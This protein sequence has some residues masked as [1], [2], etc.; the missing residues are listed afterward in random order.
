MA[1]VHEVKS[2]AKDYP[3]E[4]IKK[5]EPYY[6]W[7][8]RFGGKHR[9]KTP[10]KPQQLTQ[11]EFAKR[12]MAASETLGTLS[13]DGIPA[14][15]ETLAG[16]ISDLEELKTENEDKLNNM[17]EG[18]QEGEV[19]QLIQERVDTLENATS[20]LE[21]AK[22]ELES[23]EEPEVEEPTDEE[24]LEDLADELKDD[25]D[26]SPEERDRLVKDRKDEMR[27]E[28][29]E[30]AQEERRQEAET[31]IENAQGVDLGG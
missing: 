18:L 20:E 30:E 7:A 19:G 3:E 21:D 27:D 4:H 11:S 6:W 17:P 9:S 1:R 13:A 5:G 22:G 12:T 8:F 15:I 26:M 10:P 24:V 25:P 14:A 29:M 28:R 16:V 31:A 2:A 23:I